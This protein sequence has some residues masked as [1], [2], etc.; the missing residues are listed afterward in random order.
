IKATI[1]ELQQPAEDQSPNL[2]SIVDRIRPSVRSL[3]QTDL[4]NDLDKLAQHAVRANVAMSV[5]HLRHGS[6]LLERL[7]AEGGLA[8]VGAEY[9]LQTGEVEFFDGVPLS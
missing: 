9:S 6:A 3:L 1:Q 2:K 7:I 5:D 8:I 4:K